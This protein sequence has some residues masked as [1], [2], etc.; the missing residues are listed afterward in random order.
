MLLLQVVGIEYEIP[1]KPSTIKMVHGC[2]A[3][4]VV[5]CINRSDVA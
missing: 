4:L 3:I 1:T 5:L 2:A